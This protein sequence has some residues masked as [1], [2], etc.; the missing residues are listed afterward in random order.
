MYCLN[1]LAIAL[2]LAKENKAYEDVA[3]S[4]SS[5][6]STLRAAMNNIGDKRIA[7]WDERGRV[8]LRRDALPD[9]AQLPLRVRSMVGLDPALRG[10]DIEPEC[11]SS[12]PG[13]KRRLEWFLSTARN[14]RLHRAMHHAGRRAAFARRWCAA[15]G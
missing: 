3:S 10:R 15:I 7:L 1:M 6:S 2:E 5:I 14:W 12:L 4:S 8:L 9:G 13:F 11:S